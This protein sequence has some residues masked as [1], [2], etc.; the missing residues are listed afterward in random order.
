MVQHS[1]C[2]KL[3][4]IFILLDNNNTTPISF[5]PLLMGNLF[6]HITSCL[7]TAKNWEDSVSCE[8]EDFQS[9]LVNAWCYPGF[10]EPFL[11]QFIMALN[12]VLTA[13]PFLFHCSQP[14]QGSRGGSLCSFHADVCPKA[15]VC[16]P[17]Q[18]SSITASS[19][20]LLCLFYF[21]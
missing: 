16:D 18:P 17:V 13:L 21:L 8:G 19:Q 6:S 1:W 2:G 11:F 20:P 15:A 9:C 14:P 3:C 4:P 5:F 7:I 10:P 12:L